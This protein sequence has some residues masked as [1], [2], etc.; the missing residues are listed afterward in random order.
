LPRISLVNADQELSR[1]DKVM[2]KLVTR[3]GPCTLRAGRG[4]HFAAL[5]E[6]I[7]YQQLAGKAAAAIHA[8]LVG[9][10]DAGMTPEAVLA[11]PDDVL[12]RAGLSR[13]KAASIKDLADKVASG[14]VPLHDVKGV[15]DEELIARLTAVRGIGRWTA[16][17]FLMFQLRRLD[18]WPVDDYGVR[19][20]YAAAYRLTELPK[21]KELAALGE[22]FRPYRSVAAW[23]CWRAVDTQTQGRA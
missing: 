13:A 23:Y 18:V 5:V 2:A 14:V 4:D 1:R 19:K 16:E 7:V 8:R 11:A 6:S 22:R 12:A 21:P 20:G 9:Q 17:M 3:H 15:N 10:F